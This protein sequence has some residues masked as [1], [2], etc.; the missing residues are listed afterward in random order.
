MGPWKK[1]RGWICEDEAD[2]LDYKQQE[3]M[4]LYKKG[5]NAGGKVS[6][7]DTGGR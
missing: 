1:D 6:R 4:K 7:T 3:K 2:D 5:Y